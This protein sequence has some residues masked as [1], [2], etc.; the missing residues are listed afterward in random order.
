MR[1]CLF[2]LFASEDWYFYY[3]TFQQ[4]FFVLF[5]KAYL[6]HRPYAD[7]QYSIVIASFAFR[8]A[9]ERYNRDFVCPSYKD[10]FTRLLLP[11]VFYSSAKIFNASVTSSLQNPSF[12]VHPSIVFKKTTSWIGN[13]ALSPFMSGTWGMSSNYFRNTEFLLILLYT[14]VY[15]IYCV[16]LF[17]NI[18]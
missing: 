18:N 6:V 1:Y 17:R 15:S 16:C 9:G 4:L 7:F 13:T 3:C 11:N 12:S 10:D 14:Q 2:C 8:Y 5:T